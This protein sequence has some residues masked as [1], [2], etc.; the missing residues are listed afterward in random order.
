MAA[1]SL[2]EVLDYLQQLEG[3]LVYRASGEV[4]AIVFAFL[5]WF[6]DD[7]RGLA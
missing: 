7:E 5:T 1:T 2:V 6:C 4:V 3:V